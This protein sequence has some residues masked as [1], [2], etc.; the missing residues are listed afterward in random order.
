M[1]ALKYVA[2]DNLIA[3]TA[4]LSILYYI[5]IRRYIDEPSGSVKVKMVSYFNTFLTFV[6][7][8]SQCLFIFGLN[9]T[10]KEGTNFSI[11]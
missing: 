11:Y 8:R 9:P 7:F 3:Q 1:G 4:E 10:L 6:E 2:K 5:K